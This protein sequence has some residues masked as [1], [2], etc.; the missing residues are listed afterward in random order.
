MNSTRITTNPF[1][2]VK[3]SDFSDE[4][5]QQYWVD[6]AGESSLVDLFQPNLQMPMFLLGGKGSGKTHLMRY[7][8]LA[9]RKLRSDNILKEIQADKFIGIYVRAD[10][11]NVGRFNGKGEREELWEAVFSYYFELWLATHLL[12]AVRE[13]LTESTATFDE[14][15][16]VGATKELFSSPQPDAVTSLS[17]LIDHFATLRKQIDYVVGNVATKRASLSEIDICLPLGEVVFGIPELINNSTSVF[18][19][20]LFVYL[21]DEIENFT[22]TQQRFLNSLIRYRRGPV[23]IKVGARLYG[24]RTL[25]TL[26]AGEKIR[27]GAEFTKVE[28]DAWLREH[29]GKYYSL[30]N[31]LVY[32]R[33]QKAG[34]VPDGNAQQDSVAQFFETLGSADYYQKATLE[35]VRKYD[36][37][38]EDRPYFE[39]LRKNLGDWT[40]SAKSDSDSSDIDRII[41]ALKLP[42][43][44]LLEKVNIYLFYK[45]GTLDAELVKLAQT[46]S[47]E[48]QTFLTG[49]KAASNS[50][51]Q[52]L[53]H[54][55]SDLLAQLYRDCEKR[56][57]VY[58][59]FDTLVHLSQGIPRNLLGLL[60]HIYRRSH[61]AEERP[62]QLGQ[63]I[64][65]ESQVSGIRDAAA[66]F[67]E[68]AQPDIHG[69]DARRAVE[70]LAKLFS[71]VRFSLKPAEC[72]LGTFTIASN[73]GTA[74]ARE[75]LDHAE[76]WSY[77]VRVRGGGS[78]RNDAAAVDDK[79]QLSP[80]LAPRWEISEHRRGA[81]QLTENLFNAIF[82][83]TQRESAENLVRERLKQMQNPFS[84]RE[85]PNVDQ[86]QLF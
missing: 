82:D 34:F 77:L 61:F 31:E 14:G 35:V 86:S 22:A 46:I 30:A 51:F 47:Q 37:K 63:Q 40:K 49:G 62:F 17:D 78:D 69:P 15:A 12:K 7:Y 38:K 64:S 5:I 44:P 1:D 41:A 8:S 36:L 67:W 58:A 26:G 25:E 72:D 85:N 19:D 21:I 32:K 80:M 48:A 65:I 45:R 70:M 2:L 6:L 83:P 13:C 39:S 60:R 59:G 57:V 16:F 55:K 3:A 74:S 54:F 75:V 71:G 28:L 66:W 29:E 27:E 20:V 52:V 43:Y 24:V 42:Q 68:D 11:L 50:Y 23:S 79:Y 4:Q 73:K 84:K 10:G 18:K 53:D 81:I 76:N 33:L 56:R 9:V